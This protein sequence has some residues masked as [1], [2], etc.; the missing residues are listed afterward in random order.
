MELTVSKKAKLNLESLA[1][2][3]GLPL[4]TALERVLEDASGGKRKAAKAAK[5]ARAV[6]AG[7]VRTAKPAKATGA[8]KPAKA[9][10]GVH[11]R[12]VTRRGRPPKAAA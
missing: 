3:L 4:G 11:L 7:A 5:P 10:R 2:R 6:K 8:A 9:E 12:L 1:E